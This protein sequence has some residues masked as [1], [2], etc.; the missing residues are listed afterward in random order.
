MIIKLLREGY[1]SNEEFYHAFLKN[2]ISAYISNEDEVFLSEAPDF[3]IYLGKLDDESKKQAFLQMIETIS[4]HFL[5][6]D[7]KYF[8]GEIF[9]HS[10]LCLC[11]REYLLNSYPEI[12]E[13]YTFFKNIVIKNFDWE[14]YIYK[15]VLIAQ[16]VNNGNFPQDRCQKYYHLIIENLDVFNYII[17]YEIFRNGPFLLN[18]LDIIEETGTSKILKSK[19]KNRSDLGKDERYGR[20]VIYE[21]NKSYPVILSPMLSKDE[22]KPYFLQ[23]LNLY[24]DGEEIREEADY[25]LE[26]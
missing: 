3:P 18:I 8:F 5:S 7:R 25:W 6:L 9:W 24:Y 22:L 13:N 21:F 20:R 23:F 10:Y 4:S 1:K 19:I 12:K 17:K 14:N 16:Y 26:N 2:E 11:K 15:S